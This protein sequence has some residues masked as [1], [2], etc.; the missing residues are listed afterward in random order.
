MTSDLG[1]LVL[2]VMLGGLLLFHGIEKLRHGI[3]MIKALVT[4]HG[5]PELLAYGV[6]IGELLAPLLLILGFHSRVWAGII[7]LNMIMAMWLTHFKGAASLG[8]YGAWG[9]ETVAFYL[10]S[11]VAVMLLGSGRI[12]VKR[13]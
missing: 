11:A 12:A 9:M 4:G 6:Y 10:G 5:L 3:G 7:A 13:D 8:A 1:K 2:R